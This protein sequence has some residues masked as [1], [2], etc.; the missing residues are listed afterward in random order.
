MIE[1]LPDGLTPYKRTPTFTEETI[2]TGLLNDDQ[3]KDGN[4]G[5]IRVEEASCAIS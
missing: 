3:T 1:R 5:L 4:W 2:P